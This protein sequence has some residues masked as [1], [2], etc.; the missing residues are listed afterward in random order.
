MDEEL[1]FYRSAMYLY[2]GER[3]EIKNLSERKLY[4]W[5][6]SRYL[7]YKMHEDET[8]GPCV[9]DEYGKPFILGS[10]KYIS[11]LL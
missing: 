11:L 8:R 5:Y 2:D 10:P 1:D 7:L 6:A 9:K 3:E 4:E